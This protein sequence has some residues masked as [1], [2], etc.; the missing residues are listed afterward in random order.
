M[1]HSRRI[2]RNPLTVALCAAMLLPGAALA[3]TQNQ[4][5]PPP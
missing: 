2:N 1:P 5:D 3:Q 4:Q